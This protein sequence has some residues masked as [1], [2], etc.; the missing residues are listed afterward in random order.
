M[1]KDMVLPDEAIKKLSEDAMDF[2]W[3]RLADWKNRRRGNFKISERQFVDEVA[4]V[5]LAGNL[6]AAEIFLR[7]VDMDETCTRAD[8]QAELHLFLL[9]CVADI[10][11]KM[12]Q[13]KVQ[14]DLEDLIDG[15]YSTD[16]Y[17]TKN[18]LRPTEE[19]EVQLELGMN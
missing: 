12:P 9:Q 1:I 13:L 18:N 14:V 6:S 8:I 3:I 15:K 19:T 10:K 2:A 5:W 17:L 7:K 4:Y 11:K 16:N